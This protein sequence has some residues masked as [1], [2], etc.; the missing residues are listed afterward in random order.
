MHYA[1]LYYIIDIFTQLGAAAV[2]QYH[3]TDDTS[4]TVHEK[5][6][7]LQKTNVGESVFKIIKDLILPYMAN[8]K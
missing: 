7:T 4:I 2:T 1:K 3:Q 8:M 6:K 5:R